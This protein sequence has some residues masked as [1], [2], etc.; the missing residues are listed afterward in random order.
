[1]KQICQILWCSLFRVHRDISSGHNCENYDCRLIGRH[2]YI[3]MYGWR[4]ASFLSLSRNSLWTN[5]ASREYKNKSANKGAQLGP[6]WFPTE[7]WK[8]RPH[9]HKSFKYSHGNSQLKY[10]NHRMM[11]LRISSTLTL[12]YLS[13]N[14]QL[15][16][17]QTR[18]FELRM[19]LGLSLQ[20]L[21]RMNLIY[22]LCSITQGLFIDHIHVAT[23]ECLLHVL[24]IYYFINHEEFKT[25][26][27]A[28]MSTVTY[29]VPDDHWLDTDKHY[30]HKACL[31]FNGR[32][33]H[34]DPGWY[35]SSRSLCVSYYAAEWVGPSNLDESRKAKG[36]VS[37]QLWHDKIPS[38]SKALS[39]EH[40]PKFWSP[41]PAMMT[42]PHKW[43]NLEQDVKQ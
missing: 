9:R 26:C 24:I 8:T 20:R 18:I 11:E 36:P 23:I 4:T 12:S 27:M 2:R 28:R 21:H 31:E 30:Q 19:T 14:S 3:W 39:A 10:L 22:F 37:Q 15:C 35:R 43:K 40:R 17:S 33:T 34:D 7:C 29:F 38:C 42:S 13:M 16:R 25:W 32:W 5:S 41:S 6:I 1:M